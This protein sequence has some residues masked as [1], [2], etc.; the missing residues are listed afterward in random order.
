VIL[1]DEPYTGL[2]EAAALSL[3]SLLEDLATRDRVL[4]VTLHDVSR[5]ISGPERLVVLSAGRIVLDTPTH[6]RGADVA[7]TYLDLLRAE[8]AR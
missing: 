7:E 4:M 6:E 8:V 1:L 3:S 5:A 2:D